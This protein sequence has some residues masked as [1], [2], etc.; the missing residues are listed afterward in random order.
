M[1]RFD[2][3]WSSSIHERP[4]VGGGRF[5]QTV[6]PPGAWACELKMLSV[7]KYKWLKS[8][9]SSPLTYSPFNIVVTSDG[10]SWNSLYQLAACTLVYSLNF[11]ELA[12]PTKENPYPYHHFYRILPHSLPKPQYNPS[13]VPVSGCFLSCL[14]KASATLRIWNMESSQPQQQQGPKKRGRKPKPKDEKEQQQQQQSA[15]KMKEGKKSQQ[16][17]VD[18]KYT[19][20]KSLVPVLY[21]WL[22]NHNLVWPSLSCRFI[23]LTPFFFLVVGHCYFSLQKLRFRVLLLKYAPFAF[24]VYLCYYAWF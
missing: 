2:R 16:P 7:N 20:W 24:R 3:M 13:R 12:S 10:L 1:I 17:S 9:S 15:G 6:K 22:A 19:Q 8:D 21:D 4:H 11:K 18:E 23:S 5:Q 14:V